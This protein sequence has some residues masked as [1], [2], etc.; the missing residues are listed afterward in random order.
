MTIWTSPFSK[1]KTMGTFKKE[2]LAVTFVVYLEIFCN[3]NDTLHRTCPLPKW[4]IRWVSFLD[5]WITFTNLKSFWDGSILTFLNL[6][7]LNR[8]WIHETN[9]SLIWLV[10]VSSTLAT[11]NFFFGTSRFFFGK[12]FTIKKHRKPWKLIISICNLTAATF[13]DLSF[14]PS[15][16]EE[17]K[18]EDFAQLTERI[19]ILVKD[20]KV[21]TGGVEDRMNPE[22]TKKQI[23]LVT[24]VGGI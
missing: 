14:S 9:K 17:M 21:E 24:F 22:T 23:I 11:A 3:A 19:L 10:E 4:L 15:Q 20:M 12:P 6:A 16:T 2:A 18:L 7:T 5:G 1:E 13:S 8:S